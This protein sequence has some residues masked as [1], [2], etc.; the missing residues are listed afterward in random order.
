MIYWLFLIR[1]LFL[2]VTNVCTVIK[3][4]KNIKTFALQISIKSFPGNWQKGRQ[5][6]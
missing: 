1:L 6:L 5:N 2:F 3:R 4:Q